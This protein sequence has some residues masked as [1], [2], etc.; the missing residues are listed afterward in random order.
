MRPIKRAVETVQRLTGRADKFTVEVDD[1]GITIRPRRAR[2][3]GSLEHTILW[4]ALYQHL[5]IAA[6]DAAR[7]AKRGPR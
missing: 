2:R 4:G 7:R 5:V 1:L 3:G 6:V